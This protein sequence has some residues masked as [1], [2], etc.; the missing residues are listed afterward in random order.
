MV[1]SLIRVTLWVN[2]Q[3]H[4]FT[5]LLNLYQPATNEGSWLCAVGCSQWPAKETQSLDPAGKGCVPVTGDRQDGSGAGPCVLGVPSP[6]ARCPGAPRHL[7]SCG[8]PASCEGEQS[9]LQ[10]GRDAS[11]PTWVQL[12]FSLLRRAL[13]GEA[14]EHGQRPGSATPRGPHLPAGSCI[15]LLHG[16]GSTASSQSQQDHGPELKAHPC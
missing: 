6:S 10:E 13:I 1:L 11:V 2:G 8:R 4:K 12:L 9:P 14:G 3:V 15:P 5:Q 7:L 16:P